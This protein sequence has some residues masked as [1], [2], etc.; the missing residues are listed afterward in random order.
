MH[1]HRSDRRAFTL[2][3]LLVVIAIIG[4]LTGLLLPAVQMARE[5]ARRTQCSNNLRQ[6]GIALHNYHGVRRTLPPGCLEWRPPKGPNT[7]KQFAWSAMILP[8]LEQTELYESIDFRVPYDAPTNFKAGSVSLSVY[9]CPSA[10]AP[11][12]GGFG[13]T[14]YA[15]IYGQRITT[16]TNTNNGV[17]IYERAYRFEDIRDGLSQTI[18]VAEDTRGPDCE[19]INGRNT[20]EQSGGINDP[21]AASF[22]NEIRSDH[23]GGAM[24]L[25]TDGHVSLLENGLDKTILAALITRYNRDRIPTT[26]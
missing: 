26:Y 3:E 17:F 8:Y 11:P 24:V 7:R 15:G 2:V 5:A 18:C 21:K 13:K 25:F 22:D 6:I 20:F 1:A 16:F 10:V 14:D 4:I 23:S 9:R 12:P 19:W